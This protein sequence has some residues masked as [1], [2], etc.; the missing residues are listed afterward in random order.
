MSTSTSGLKSVRWTAPFELNR[1][2]TV[3]FEAVD[4]PFLTF[5]GANAIR[6]CRESGLGFDG[7]SRG[8]RR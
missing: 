5:A 3:E 6:R 4:D 2:A 1:A 8:C 7:G